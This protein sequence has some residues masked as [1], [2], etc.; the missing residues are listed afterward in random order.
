MRFTILD[1][2]TDEPAGLG[3]P[4][5]IGTYPRYVYG[6]VKEAG[7][8]VNYLTVD[9]LRAF[10]LGKIK[11]KENEIKTNIKIRNLSNNF[12]EISKILEKT[13]ILIVICGVHTPGKYL[14]ALPGTTKEV[15]GLLS[16]IK[17]NFLTVLSGPAAH[18]GSGLWGG[19]IAR[20]VAKDFDYFDLVIPDIEFKI[21]ELKENNFSEDVKVE[22]DYSVLREKAILG[23]EIVKFHPCFPDFLMAEI[24]TSRGCAR[25]EGC[26]FCTEPLKYCTVERR[27]VED[28]I[29]EVKTLA[30]LGV[31]NF[32][33]GKQSCFYSY[34]SAAEIEKL[35]KGCRQYAEILHIDNVNPIF[36]D[37]EKTKLIVRYCSPGNVAAFGVESFDKEVIRKNK[38]NSVP[39][40]TFE[41]I[42]I[43]NKYG[44]VRGS[45]GLPKFLPGINLIF[46][47]IGESK[48]TH[49][50]NMFWLQKILDENLMVRRINVREVVVF[51]GTLLYKEAGDKFLKKNRK[52]YFRWRKE[53]R[54]KI[55]N[56]MLKKVVPTGNVMKD[57]RTEIYDGKTTFCRQIGTYPLVVG[58]K[59]RLGLDKFVDVKVVGHQLRSVVGEKI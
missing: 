10:V 38:L 43:I 53:I 44:A 40:K 29:D 20:D 17:N 21:V 47:L 16:Q 34:G 6:A 9:D 23:A 41:A 28:I 57:L 56:E 45:N 12:S 25:K 8:E 50:E 31:K 22:M 48:K 18:Y 51:P 30:D 39:E 5:Y 35:L 32:R 59:G 52:Y 58:V 26:S 24:E 46:G 27:E 14:S 37:E 4:P 55:D 54:A 1:C 33:L 42:K 49:K 11:D 15:I 19:R 36:V 7:D 2:Y 3:V 13:N